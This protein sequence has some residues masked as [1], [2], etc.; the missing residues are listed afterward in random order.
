M[1]KLGSIDDGFPKKGVTLHSR[2]V[3]WSRWRYLEVV[4]DSNQKG[5]TVDSLPNWFW[6]WG[7]NS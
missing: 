1:G 4:L 6:I 2:A 3:G 7:S 5:L